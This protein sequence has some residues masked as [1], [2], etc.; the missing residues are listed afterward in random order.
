MYRAASLLSMHIEGATKP[1]AGERI[2]KLIQAMEWLPSQVARH[3]DIAAIGRQTTHALVRVVEELVRFG[4]LAIKESLKAQDPLIVNQLLGSVVQ[5]ESVQ[6]FIKVTGISE[7]GI[8]LAAARDEVR[9]N[10]RQRDE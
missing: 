1:I 4:V 5:A 3:E 9:K 7:L 2:L 6:L 8:L 10:V